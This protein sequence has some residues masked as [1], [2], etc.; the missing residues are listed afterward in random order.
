MSTPQTIGN[1]RTVS[2]PRHATG[3][4]TGSRIQ[5]RIASVGITKCSR[6]LDQGTSTRTPRLFASTAIRPKT[7]PDTTM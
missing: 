2:A 1:P 5:S 3:R 7:I 6:A 4:R